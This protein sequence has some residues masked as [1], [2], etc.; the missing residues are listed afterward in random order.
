M[1]PAFHVVEE[2]VSNHR[3]T[4]GCGLRLLDVQPGDAGQYLVIFPARLEDNRRMVLEMEVK[5]NISRT[6]LQA[7]EMP[8]RTGEVVALV[9][10]GTFVGAF[11]G[12]IIGKFYKKI[13][14]PAYITQ[15]DP[16]KTPT[17][18]PLKSPMKK[19]EGIMNSPLLKSVTKSLKKKLMETPLK[20]LVKVYGGIMNSLTKSLKKTTESIV[21]FCKES[22]TK[23]PPESPMK[24][25]EE[26][27]PK[28]CQKTPH[29]ENT[30]FQIGRRTRKG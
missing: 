9:F 25:L 5:E 13:P 28:N 7:E 16:I 26:T 2:V 19:G 22:P 12:I 29:E 27:T 8:W 18:S 24:T 4:V 30:Q 11:F 1:D 23:T 15:N 3:V 6:G 20:S 21:K 10:V 17:K 14:F